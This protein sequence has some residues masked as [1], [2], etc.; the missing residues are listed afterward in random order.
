M[1]ERLNAVW[2]YVRTIDAGT[3]RSLILAHP[4]PQGQSR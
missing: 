3:M 1:R 2:A 4:Q